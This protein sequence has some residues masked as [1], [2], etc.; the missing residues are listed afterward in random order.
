MIL[1]RYKSENQES[2]S[3]GKNSNNHGVLHVL[4]IK[5]IILIKWINTLA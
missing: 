5:L 3:D 1:I 4:K 2:S